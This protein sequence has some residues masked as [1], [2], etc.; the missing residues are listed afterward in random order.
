MPATYDISKVHLFDVDVPNGPVLMESRTTAPGDKV[1]TMQTAMRQCNAMLPAE[2]LCDTRCGF[3]GFYR[4]LS[5]R[6]ELHIPLALPPVHGYA[7]IP[8]VTTRQ[9]RADTSQLAHTVS[10]QKV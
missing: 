3:C 9:C 1:I 7:C 5:Q 4:F 6:R 2:D 8:L 10:L